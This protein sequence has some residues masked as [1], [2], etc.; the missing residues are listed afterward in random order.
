[1]NGCN[2]S[3]LHILEAPITEGPVSVI[4]AFG[5]LAP[6]GLRRLDGTGPLPGVAATLCLWP[7]R[8]INSSFREGLP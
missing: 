1:M 4:L 5:D 8:A 3:K 6:T 7:V 2:E